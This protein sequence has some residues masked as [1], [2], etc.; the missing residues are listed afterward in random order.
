MSECVDKCADIRPYNDIDEVADSVARLIADNA[1][2]DVI[3]K[4]NLRA[5]LSLFSIYK[6]RP[7][8]A[9]A[10]KKKVGG[11]TQSVEQVQQEVA[12]YLNKLI[13]RTTSESDIF[14]S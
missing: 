1:F 9:P 5:L 7:L 11:N 12:S 14:G 2:V 10:I 8:V 13:T 4:Y 6:L 3:A